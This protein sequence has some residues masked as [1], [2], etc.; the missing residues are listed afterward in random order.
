MGEDAQRRTKVLEYMGLMDWF[1][2][3]ITAGFVRRNVRVSDLFFFGPPTLIILN[4][5]LWAWKK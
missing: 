4:A 1:F 3:L 5:A 2:G